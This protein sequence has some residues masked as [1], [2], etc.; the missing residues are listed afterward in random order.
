M[1]LTGTC[2]YLLNV[3]RRL[4]VGGHFGGFYRN[5]SCSM[6]NSLVRRMVVLFTV[7][8]TNSYTCYTTAVNIHNTTYSFNTGCQTQP[9]KMRL[10]DSNFSV[11][12]RNVSMNIYTTYG[13]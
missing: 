10:T 11:S 7:L 6:T 2:L 4:D 13:L 8:Y 1:A 9:Y 12:L 5:K 3:E